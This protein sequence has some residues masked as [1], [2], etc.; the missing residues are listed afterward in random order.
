MH[1]VVPTLL[2]ILWGPILW[3]VHL[4]VTYGAQS[5]TCAIG[6]ARFAAFI[7]ALLLAATALFAILLLAGFCWPKPAARLLQLDPHDHPQWRFV[8]AVS[9]NLV[10]LSFAGVIF[11]GMAVL[12]IDPCAQLR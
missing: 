11:N 5:A 3:A 8:H 7:P 6:E 2:M 4:L 10:A 1:P 12:L 9:R